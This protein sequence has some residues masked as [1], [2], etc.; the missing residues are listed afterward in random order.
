MKKLTDQNQYNMKTF[1]AVIFSI[2][3]CLLAYILDFTRVQTVTIL[4]HWDEHTLLVKGNFKHIIEV[5]NALVFPKNTTIS[6]MS[7]KQIQNTQ[8]YVY[9]YFTIEP[10][11]MKSLKP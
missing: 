4:D 10:K 11:V 5:E 2:I 7:I 3:L 6:G 8:W 9:S 1:L